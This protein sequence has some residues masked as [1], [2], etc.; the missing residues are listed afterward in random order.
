[1]DEGRAARGTGLLLAVLALV[2]LLAPP[3]AADGGP[4]GRDL[5]I[6]QSLGDREL[7]VELRRVA[8]VP[9]PLRVD[10]TQHAGTTG[11][12]LVLTV[13]ADGLDVDRAVVELPDRPGAGA[14]ATLAVDHAGPFELAVTDGG[15][16]ALIPFVV[17]AV[18][19]APWERAV[20]GGWVAAGV[21]LLLALVLATRARR[22]WVPLVPAVGVVVAAAVAVTAAL[23]SAT[24]P[25]PVEPGRVT[26]P[27]RAGAADPHAVVQAGPGTSRPPVN[28]LLAAPGAV[29]GQPVDLVVDAV[30]AA[31][32]RPVDDLLVHHD[33]L[34]HL[35]VVGPSGRLWHLHPVR[36]APGRFTARVTPE[37]GRH[38]VTAE[39]ARRGG[40][41]QQVRATLDV[42]GGATGPAP[43]PA[44][45]RIDAQV[46]PAGA[47]SSLAV[48]FGRGAD[49]QPWLGMTGHLLVSGPVPEVAPDVGAAVA[50]APVWAH[51]HSTTGLPTDP[52]AGVPDSTVAAFGPQ[53]RFT[54]TFPRPGRY[55]LWFQ[56]MR[57][58]AVLTAPAEVVVPDPAAP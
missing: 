17:P 10:V 2:V 50:A 15:R 54:V 48:T 57:A 23:L 33:A 26:D 3:A 30:D 41:V 46:A 1:M 47:P 11:G 49:L 21:S 55:L 16:T 45:A 37:A 12:E 5:R 28:V 4:V 8:A 43:A 31:T 36:T 39:F 14:G 42:A 52:A 22:W 6:A 35:V 38:A 7:T 9:G 56:A 25:P 29:A 53:V 24:V 58:D 32:G 18:V 51:V 27:T 44:P 40:G 13:R 34:V 20:F 19:P